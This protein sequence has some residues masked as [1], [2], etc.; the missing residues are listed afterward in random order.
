MNPLDD[1][2]SCNLDVITESSRRRQ[3]L[4]APVQSVWSYFIQCVR[5][6]CSTVDPM[7]LVLSYHRSVWNRFLGQWVDYVCSITY[8][9]K[10]AEDKDLS[11]RDLC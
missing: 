3:H 4:F 9:N 8:D 10:P 6:A 5:E 2:I 11:W 1:V 7:R